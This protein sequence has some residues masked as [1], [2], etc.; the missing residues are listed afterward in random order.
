LTV[1]HLSEGVLR[2]LHDDSFA[3]SNSERAHLEACTRCRG[4][5]E[6]VAADAAVAGRLLDLTHPQDAATEPALA[7]LRSRL[8]AGPLT[9][10]R[11]LPTPLRVRSRRLAFGVVAVPVVL[12]ALVATASA[13]GWLS[14]FSP[15]QVAPVTLTAGELNGLPDLSGYGHM[16]VTEPDVRSVAGPAAA[17]AATGMRILRPASLPADVPAQVSWEVVGHGSATFTVDAA[18]AAAAAAR[19]GVAAPSIP[20]GLNG[21]SITVE[22]GPAVVAVYGS[23]SA[24]LVQGGGDNPPTLVIA[25]AMRPTASTNGATLQQLESF[26]LSEPGVSSQLAAEIRAIGQ[27]ASTLPIPIISG[28]MTSESVTIDGVQGVAAGDSTGLGAAVI[29]EK[30][31]IVYAVGGLLAQSEVLDIARSL[32]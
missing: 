5:L 28:L 18:A 30:D 15:T 25:Q 27:P 16:K 24:G 7:R 23:G 31:G 14:V 20:A 11:A 4:R 13:E 8:A 19:A 3:A 29:W 32:R 21:T 1:R 6:I 12:G 22:A 2:R 26:L 10:R 9:R 17:A